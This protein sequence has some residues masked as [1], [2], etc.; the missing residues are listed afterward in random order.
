MVVYPGL[1]AASAGRCDELTTIREAWRGARRRN[2]GGRLPTCQ[3]VGFSTCWE[4]G[5]S[6]S[7]RGASGRG[8]EFLVYRR[9]KRKEWGWDVLAALGGVWP[10]YG[11][12]QGAGSRGEQ[13]GNGFLV[14]R[15]VR[16]RSAGERGRLQGGTFSRVRWWVPLLL[17]ARWDELERYGSGG[18]VQ[19]AW[20]WCQGWVAEVRKGAGG[21][22]FTPG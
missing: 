19:G 15:W 9:G 11:Q 14:Y 4:A 20:W 17:G 21:F 2:A 3:L 6:E 5:K 16:G 13:E 8:G 1:R 7:W 18:R 22:W 12:W 10:R